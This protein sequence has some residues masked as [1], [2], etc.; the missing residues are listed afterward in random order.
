MNFVQED[1]QTFDDG[2]VSA[3]RERSEWT[4]HPSGPL[5]STATTTLTMERRRGSW[6][7]V[8]ES[9]HRIEADPDAFH[10]RVDVRAIAGSDGFHERTY[11]WSI[12][13]DGV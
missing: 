5:A 8:L 3:H 9:T 6:H 7:A 10:V 4:S 1:E 2:L 13:R 11:T 12:P